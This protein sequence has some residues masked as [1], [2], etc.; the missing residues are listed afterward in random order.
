MRSYSYKKEV[1]IIIAFVL[2]L[3]FLPSPAFATEVDEIQETEL[4]PE[5]EKTI[6]LK[7]ESDFRESDFKIIPLI[8]IT[9]MGTYSDVSGSDNLIGADIKGSLAPVVRLDK[10]S[11]II[12]LYYGAYNRERQV[13]VEEEGGRVYNEIVDQNAT[14]Q[15][16]YVMDEKRT[17]KLDGLA[18]LHYV[19]EKGYDWADGL[20]DYRDFGGGSS[21]EYTLF[22]TDTAKGVASMGGEFYYRQYP[23][24]QSLISLATT[25]APETDEKDYYGYRSLFRYNYLS[26]KFRCVFFYSPVFKDFADKKVVGS[27]GVLKS[28]ERE[29]W[30]HYG[31]LEGFYLPEGI[32]FGFGLKFTGILVDSNQNYYDSKS[33]V[34]LGDDVFT[35]NYYSFKSLTASPY[36][37]YIHRLKDKKRPATVTAGYAYLARD[38]DDRKAQTGDGAY[39]DN[40]QLD[41]SHTINLQAD[42]PINDYIS[43]VGLAKYTK[44]LSNMR[45]E[46]YYQYRYNS[47]YAAAGIK[48]KY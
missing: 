43:V 22:E 6:E 39:T 1:Y 35:E 18:R 14:L 28:E 32:P 15:Y 44:A 5:L 8:D 2:C 16:K 46:T 4:S 37:T 23:N 40:T 10:K 38:Y 19:K 33:T 3:M 36:I 26:D 13:V 45:Y 20:Y 42:Y 27:D 12:P 7:K 48:I 34:G 31:R 41:Q 29:D 30:F 17:I 9:A 25:T 11:Y 47:V 24:Y 21:F